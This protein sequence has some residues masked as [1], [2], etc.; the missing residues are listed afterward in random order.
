MLFSHFKYRRQLSLFLLLPA[1]LWCTGCRRAQPTNAE[2]QAQTEQHAAETTAAVEIREKTMVTL[3]DSIAAG[4]GLSDAP[5]QRYSALTAAALTQQE[6]NTHW[7]EYNY[8]ISGDDSSDLLS[9]LQGELPELQNADLITVCIGANNVLGPGIDFLSA[10]VEQSV[11]TDG[12]VQYTVNS[13]A[14]S[15]SYEKFKT[16]AAGGTDRLREDLKQICQLIRA[17]NTDAPLYFLSV[18]NPYATVRQTIPIGSINVPFSA[19]SA[20]AVRSVNRVLEAC[21]PENGYRLVPVAQAFADTETVLVN[22]SDPSSP[23]S[24]PD[25]HPNAAGHRVIA[26]TL[27]QAILSPEPDASASADTESTAHT[28][29]ADAVPAS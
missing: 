20:A 15:K 28:T 5:A 12:S 16:D 23:F 3:G 17:Q 9:L 21:A 1:L 7:N 27:V 6:K 26:Q 11:S 29:S 13:A 8:A 2:A 10:C 18:Y 25:P 4:Y 19:L 22:A 24:Y 14:V